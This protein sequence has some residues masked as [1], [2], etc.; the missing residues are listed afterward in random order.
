[1]TEQFS[2][3]SPET[4][5]G[6][7]IEDYNNNEQQSD[8]RFGA[9]D[10]GLNFF[11]FLHADLESGDGAPLH[12]S[13]TTTNPTSSPPPSTPL[14]D[15]SLIR[16]ARYIDSLFSELNPS[17]KA[18]PKEIYA[19][20]FNDLNIV[21]IHEAIRAK[22]EHDAYMASKVREDASKLQLK[23]SNQNSRLTMVERREL[24]NTANEMKTAAENAEN[25]SGWKVYSEEVKPLIKEYI[26]LATLL[27]RGT[28]LVSGSPDKDEP[29]TRVIRR[30]AIIHE[31]LSIAENYIEMH[32]FQTVPDVINCPVCGASN[33]VMSPS[34]VFGTRVCACGRVAVSV[35]KGASF[36]D[37]ARVDTGTKNSYD[38][39]GNFSKRIDAFEGRQRVRPPQLLYEQ[40]DAFFK[41]HPEILGRSNEQ[42]RSEP[43]H[44]NG[45]KRGT[46]V[47]ILEDA[48]YKTRN[49]AFYRDIELIG[50]VIWGWKLA[51]LTYLRQVLIGDYIKTQRVY[52]EIKE[53]E[54]SLNVSLR[55]FAHLR[56]RGYPCSI[57]DFKIVSSR[58]SIAYHNKCL[59]VMFKR[60]GL[61]YEPIL[62]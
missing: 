38:D 37:S 46:S 44:D 20:Y 48:L 28:V 59:S 24:E 33:D 49:S 55:L 45:K 9:D 26:K 50:N 43:C 22:F 19:T 1:M 58:D 25:F 34:D 35:S 7:R 18:G 56:A 4:F 52:E 11:I 21:K 32:V 42:I 27:S 23:A 57:K 54:S 3:I 16:S 2:V 10:D 53:R 8:L 62:I 31:Y 51:D 47:S 29:E 61:P 15:S 36:R 5:F 39:L 30:T 12:T 17:E 41:E 13:S 6:R 14:T 40:L 60:V